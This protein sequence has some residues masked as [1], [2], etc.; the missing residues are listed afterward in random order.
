MAEKERPSLTGRRPYPIYAAPIYAIYAAGKA[1]DRGFNAPWP[2]DG[3]MSIS[4]L[5]R[6]IG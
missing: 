6:R 5:S 2:I 4:D 3:S 1:E